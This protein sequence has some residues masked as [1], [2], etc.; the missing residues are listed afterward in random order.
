VLHCRAVGWERCEED[1]CV[2]Q[3]TVLIPEKVD[4]KKEEGN[5]R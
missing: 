5:A 3:I 4:N 1:N 2:T